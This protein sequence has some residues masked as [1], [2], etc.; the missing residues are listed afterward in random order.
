MELTQNAEIEK[1]YTMVRET[2]IKQNFDETN[3]V[4]LVVLAMQ[5]SEQFEEAE[6]PKKKQM[7]TAVLNRLTDELPIP[8]NVRYLIKFGMPS[9]ID[10]IVSASKGEVAINIK[11]KVSKCF[12]CFK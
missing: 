8:E 5:I 1:L 9:V 6:G 2:A 3:W 12:S 4:G 11:K 7:V 10:G